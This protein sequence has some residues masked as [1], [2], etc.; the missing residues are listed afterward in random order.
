MTQPKVIATCIVYSAYNLLSVA[1]VTCTCNPEVLRTRT[2]HCTEMKAFLILASCC[3]YV[4]ASLNNGL[5]K[6][7]QMGWNSWYHFYCNIDAQ[8]VMDTADAMVR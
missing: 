1:I 2:C 3:F 8:I 5:G 6:K 4:G 7:P